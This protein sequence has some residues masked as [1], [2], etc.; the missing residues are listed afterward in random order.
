MRKIALALG[1]AVCLQPMGARADDGIA[2]QYQEASTAVRESLANSSLASAAQASEKLPELVIE[3][4]GPAF[5]SLQS[6]NYIADTGPD[7]SG[8]NGWVDVSPSWE[9]VSRRP[10]GLVARVRRQDRVSCTETYYRKLRLPFQ[11]QYRCTR[12]NAVSSILLT[13]GV[14]A[15][16]PAWDCRLRWL[17]GRCKLDPDRLAPQPG[18]FMDPGATV[19]VLTPTDLDAACAAPE[20]E[21]ALRVRISRVQGRGAPE[22]SALPVPARC[23]ASGKT[24]SLRIETQAGW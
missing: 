6:I 23:E 19:L 8:T 10:D 12:R 11:S 5:K 2:R 13:F 20:T 16:E 7:G 4:T 17:T 22:G 9:I 15:M 14:A 3:V 1:T 21:R 18:T 24:A